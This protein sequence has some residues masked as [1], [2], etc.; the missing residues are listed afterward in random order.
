MTYLVN[1]L[2]DAGVF[3]NIAKFKDQNNGSKVNL[4]E[5]FASI[6][7]TILSSLMGMC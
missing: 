3:S 2:P 5:L 1:T 6:P 4:Y 7:D